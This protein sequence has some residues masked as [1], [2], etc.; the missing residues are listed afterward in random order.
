LANSG[1]STAGDFAQTNNCPL[2]LAPGRPCTIKV[3]FT[4]TAIGARSGQLIVTD[5][6]STSPQ[7]V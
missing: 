6:D 2:S 4:P 5:S 7:T 1:I 3:T